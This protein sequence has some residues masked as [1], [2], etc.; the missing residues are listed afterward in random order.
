[1]DT[2]TK[3]LALGKVLMTSGINVMTYKNNTFT[4]K[5]S[6][7]LKRHENC[8]W[9]DLLQEDKDLNDEALAIGGR[10]LSSYKIDIDDALHKNIW[11]ITE[12]DRSSTTVLFPSEY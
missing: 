8:D 11:I 7:C 12:Y 10:L 9:G 1:M 2:K 6:E 5:V 4:K 3:T